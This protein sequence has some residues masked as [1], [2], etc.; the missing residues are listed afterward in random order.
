[1]PVAALGSGIGSAVIGKHI[2]VREI[3][4]PGPA[5]LKLLGDYGVATVHEAQGR[6]GLMR[7]YMRPVYTAARVS[8]S[9]VT[10]LC[11]P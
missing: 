7:P 6:S 4:R 1:M 5:D 9:A 3:S 8:G 10:V 11:T 2:V